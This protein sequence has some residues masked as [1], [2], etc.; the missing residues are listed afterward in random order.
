MII[1]ANLWPKLASSESSRFLCSLISGQLLLIAIV[2][3]EK[4]FTFIIELI[5]QPKR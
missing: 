5:K 3:G 1:Q 4:T 2:I